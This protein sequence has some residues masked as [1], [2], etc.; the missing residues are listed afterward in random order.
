M[1][2]EIGGSTER[3]GLSVSSVRF[4][5]GVGSS[6]NETVATGTRGVAGF[7][8]SAASAFFALG[9]GARVG[10]F[11]GAA[12]LLLFAFS[13]DDDLVFVPPRE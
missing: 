9:A 1:M 6:I 7:G 4:G 12:D 10:V 13:C 8:F 2:R 3:F 11:A 5:F